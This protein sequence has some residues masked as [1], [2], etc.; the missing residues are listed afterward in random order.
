MLRAM[1]ALAQKFVQRPELCSDDA[2]AKVERASFALTEYLEAVLKGKTVSP[3]ALFPQYRDVQ[4]LAVATGCIRPT[5]GHLSGAGSDPQV[6]RSPSSRCPMTPPC[7]RAWT[8]RC[9]RSSV[10]R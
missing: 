10:R 8:R 5:S 9:S 3:V 2:A 1:E 7:V 6:G 4:E